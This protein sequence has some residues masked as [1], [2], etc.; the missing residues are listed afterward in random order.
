MENRIPRVSRTG[1]H[2]E[3]VCLYIYI[4]FMIIN[5]LV[6]LFS[7]KVDHNQSV[8][9]HV[10]LM[11]GRSRR[12]RS[13]TCNDFPIIIEK[14]ICIYHSLICDH[15]YDG[16]EESDSTYIFPGKD[17]FREWYWFNCQ[18]VSQLILL[19]TLR[20]I[21]AHHSQSFICLCSSPLTMTTLGN[22]IDLRVELPPCFHSSSCENIIFTAR[23]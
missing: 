21:S 1:W 19:P 6:Y 10:Q 11:E 12:W 7:N 14:Y 15:W 13:R 4:W 2:D 3:Y 23:L 9:V 17:N 18:N 22:R 16:F 5:M 8:R 20:H